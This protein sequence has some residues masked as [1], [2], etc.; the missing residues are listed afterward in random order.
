[1][2]QPPEESNTDR[3]F[4]NIRCLAYVFPA[5]DWSTRDTENVSHS[6]FSSHHQS[7]FSLSNWNIGT[8]PDQSSIENHWMIIIIMIHEVP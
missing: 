5:N 6:M 7:F 8:K 1:M 3:F 2:L 4:Y